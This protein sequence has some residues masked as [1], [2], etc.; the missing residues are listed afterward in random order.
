MVDS[1]NMLSDDKADSKV[2]EEE[3]DDDQRDS[4]RKFPTNHIH[5]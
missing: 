4:E 3:E 2:R 5:L 1:L